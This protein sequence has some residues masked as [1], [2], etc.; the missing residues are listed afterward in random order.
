MAVG[1]AVAALINWVMCPFDRVVSRGEVPGDSPG[2]VPSLSDMVGQLHQTPLS[3]F[4]CISLK[5]VALAPTVWLLTSDA[6]W[7]KLLA[8]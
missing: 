2:C 6:F 1:T 7:T 3:L 5:A 4:R 8:P